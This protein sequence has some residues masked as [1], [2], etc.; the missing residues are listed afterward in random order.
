MDITCLRLE[1]YTKVY[2]YLIIDNFSRAVLGCK[3]S[4]FNHAQIA[5][6][7][8][9]EVVQKYGL[10]SQQV[11]LYTDGGSE[12]KGSVAEWLKKNEN[13]FTRIF[14]HQHKAITNNLIE[15]FN[16]RIKE[17]FL[18]RHSFIS[19]AVLEK[20]IFGELIPSYMSMP[21]GAL[22]G[23]TPTQVL[24]GKIPDKN[25]FKSRIAATKKIRVAENKRICCIRN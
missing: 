25:E 24:K 8:I 15:S 3:V 11:E 1:D 23:S 9:K 10:A 16:K 19:L 2:I 7:N 6:D 21:L 14:T 20:F 22:F 5:A 4:I 13:N 17:I 18:Y 12:N